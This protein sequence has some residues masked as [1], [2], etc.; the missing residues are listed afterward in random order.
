[1]I[2]GQSLP[3]IFASEEAVHLARGLGFCELLAHLNQACLWSTRSWLLPIHADEQ[4]CPFQ[5]WGRAWALRK[6]S[7]AFCLVFLHA[8]CWESVSGAGFQSVNG[9][10][11]ASSDLGPS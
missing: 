1:M 11:W 4:P 8:L 5:G 10:A 9:I 6:S 7:Q 2:G 3:P